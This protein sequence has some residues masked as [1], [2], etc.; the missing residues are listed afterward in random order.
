MASFSKVAFATEMIINIFDPSP[1]IVTTGP[2][3][4]SHSSTANL[5]F[6]VCQTVR[7][8]CRPAIYHV[9]ITLPS[10]IVFMSS[11]LHCLHCLHV[12]MSSCLN[13]LHCLHCLRFLH[14]LR[15]LFWKHLGLSVAKEKR[16]E[17]RRV[18]KMMSI[19]CLIVF[20]KN[21]N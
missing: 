14:C 11:C 9:K 16:E 18:F 10:P 7:L 15:S 12:F 13:C 2:A 19:K 8:G 6:I 20:N 1:S 17:K 3:R 5:N 4:S 21:L